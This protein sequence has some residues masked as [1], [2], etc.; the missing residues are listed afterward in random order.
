MLTLMKY[1]FTGVL[2]TNDEE[3]YKRLKFMQNSLGA[4]LSPFDCYMALRG[5][6]TLAVRMREHE[7]NALLV[8]QFLESHPTVERVL[9]PGL[10]SH[11]QHEIACKQMSGFSGMITF[12]IR[13]GERQSFTF[14]SSLKLFVCAESLG[15]VESLAESPVV[16]THASVPAAT[17]AALGISDNMIRLS[18]G[19]ENIEDLLADLSS[20]LQSVEATLQ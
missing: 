11:P 19:I 17:R 3:V 7:K 9:Y 15:A 20:A 1:C 2:A 10:P 8:A 13:G 18:I 16:M 12:Y 4:V 6:K 14:L 5:F